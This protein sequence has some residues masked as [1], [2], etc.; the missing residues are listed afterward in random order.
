MT[1]SAGMNVASLT[2]NRTARRSTAIWFVRV[3]EEKYNQGA[4]YE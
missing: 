3:I 4:A 1:E 2:Q